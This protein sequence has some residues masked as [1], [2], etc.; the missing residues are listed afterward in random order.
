LTEACPRHGKE[1]SRIHIFGNRRRSPVQT[2]NS[3]VDLRYRIESTRRHLGHDPSGAVELHAQ[4]QQTHIR[5]LR[6]HALPHLLLHGQDEDFRCGFCLEKV[7]YGSRCDVI[8]QVGYNLIRPAFGKSTW[9]TPQY[10]AVNDGHIRLSSKPLL[11][12]WNEAVI[13][14]DGDDTTRCSSD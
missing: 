2:N 6:N 14:F 12:E 8:G 3:R 11:Q 13:K 10:I 9:I 4:G 7:P 1:A 5:R